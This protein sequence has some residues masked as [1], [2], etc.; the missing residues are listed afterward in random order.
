MHLRFRRDKK[1]QFPPMSNTLWRRFS[2]Y[3][4]TWDLPR[5][6]SKE[7][8][9]EW[10]IILDIFINIPRKFQSAEV[11]N[12]RLN[13][14]KYSLCERF[15]GS[16]SVLKSG[17][18]LYSLT[19]ITCSAIPVYTVLCL[20]C[21]WIF[22]KYK[23]VNLSKQS[24]QITQAIRT[25]NVLYR[26]HCMWSSI[27]NVCKWCSPSLLAKPSVSIKNI[28][29]PFIDKTHFVSSNAPCHAYGHVIL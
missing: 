15:T 27:A 6:S 29:I 20:R 18:I 25:V 13:Q 1:I 22:E 5:A 12:L 2:G 17:A 24:A 3:T 11:I 16:W 21:R 9:W 4:Y 23:A 7:T 14:A 19:T 26:T 8:S 10:V 28:Q